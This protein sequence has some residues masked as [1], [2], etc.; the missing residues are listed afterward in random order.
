MLPP[1]HGRRMRAYEPIVRE[2][3]E[4]ELARWPLERPF[5][6][7]PRMQAVTLE[8]ILRAVFGVAEP[9][10]RERLR[11]LL[12]RLL[13]SGSSVAT[14]F[15]VLVSRRFSLPDPLARLQQLE[16]AI[17]ELL[18]AEIAERRSAAGLA[19]REDVLSLLV[20]ARFENGG[21]MSDRE[22]RDQLLTLLLAGHET[23]ATALAWTV[24]LL[25]RHPAA[26]ARLTAELGRSGRAPLRRDSGCA[27]RARHA[28]SRSGA[29]AAARARARSP[30]RAC[31][32]WSLPARCGE[33]AVRHAAQLRGVAL[34]G[35]GTVEQDGLLQRA[36]ERAHEDIGSELRVGVGD[37][38][39]APQ[40]PG[41]QGGHA[42]EARHHALAHHRV[43][44]ALDDA[45]PDDSRVREDHCDDRV[46]EALH[47]LGERR[48]GQAR[49][50][51][52]SRQRGELAV[53][54][55]QLHRAHQRRLVGHARVE[56][57]DRGPGAVGDRRHRRPVEAALGQKLL[58]GVEKPVEGVAAARLL[59][60]ANAVGGQQRLD[61][62]CGQ[63]VLR[64]SVS[65]PSASAA[66]PAPTT[67]SMSS[68]SRDPS[69]AG[70][71]ARASA[72]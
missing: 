21:A 14:Q 10:R 45:R 17:D 23:T 63:A 39:V 50:G 51:R 8:V 33:V 35:E 6:L 52:Q 70:F 37:V 38:G 25:P 46:D 48:A 24:D 28:A 55:S 60:W 34:I 20:R 32:A 16:R 40:Q 13:A 29:P 49:I 59:W 11:E 4:R 67:A 65:A 61:V 57:T 1:F 56:R 43:A 47:E 72:S 44:H 68:S 19:G 31:A 12:P 22:L 69:A 71:V 66:S 62:E 41:Q 58:G 18:L 36:G 27:R 3:V 64:R 15:R 30:A 5:A 42:L 9:R 53:Q 7:H 26:L 2:V 54:D